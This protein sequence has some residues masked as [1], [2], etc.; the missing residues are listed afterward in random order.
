M[1]KN[2]KINKPRR[3]SSFIFA[4]GIVS[5][6]LAFALSMTGGGVQ[7]APLSA[8]A[9]GLGAAA[10]YSV[11]GKAG[12]TNT[13]NSVLSGNVGADG[14]DSITGF[15]PGTAGGTVVAPEVNGAEA[16]AS[17]ADLALTAQAGDASPAGPDL[18]GLTL[19]PGVYSVGSALLSGVLTL[20]GPGVYI[21]LVASDLNSSGS[22][23]LTNGAMAC[24]VF[25]HVTS[26]AAISGG[27]FVGTIIA[28]TSIT[29]GDSVSLDGRA[30]ALTGNVTLIN[31]TISGPTC[32]A[33]STEIPPTVVPPTSSPQTEIPPTGVPPTSSPKTET[34]KA[35]ATPA[36][37]LPVTGADIAGAQALATQKWML[38]G[39]GA[40]GLGM[41]LLGFTL[42][43][44]NPKVDRRL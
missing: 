30:L 28:N 32:A 11:L 20:D 38:F 43:L 17:T 31:D 1:R 19:T 6:A 37:L 5:L 10:S 13:G 16:D 36:V 3:L 8:T 4:A 15:P 22:V 18:T 27:S 26:S 2:R 24:D 44:K 33:A 14:A 7:A 35:S 39:V 34:P 41:V 42:R 40:L 23:T 21:F 12:V 29:F 25:W 9:P